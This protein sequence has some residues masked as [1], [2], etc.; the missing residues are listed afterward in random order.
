MPFKKGL[1]ARAP[2]AVVVRQ[3]VAAGS[4]LTALGLFTNPAG[5]GESFEVVGVDAN[6]DVVG[7]ASAALDVRVVGSGVAYT[8]GASVLTATIDLTAS[9]RVPRRGALVASKLTRTI[10]SGGSLTGIL[11]GTLT[12]LV[13]LVVV[14]YLQPLIG[15][16]A[17]Q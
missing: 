11:S 16:R 12:G 9:A 8:G 10:P 1:V 5:N 3:Q 13:G 6:L 7:G 2:I 4:L 15:R 17:R 14:V